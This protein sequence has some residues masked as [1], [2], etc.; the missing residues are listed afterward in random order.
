MFNISLAAANNPVVIFLIVIGAAALIAVI[1]FTVYRLLH[2]NLK[3]GNDK[4]SEEEIA[5]EE[6]NRYLKPVEDEEIAK[7]IQEYKDEEDE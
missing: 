3:N 2:L 5:Q 4:P 7:Q 1:A 6:M